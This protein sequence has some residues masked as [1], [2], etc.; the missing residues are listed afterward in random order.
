MLFQMDETEIDH[1]GNT[2]HGM[3]LQGIFIW[4]GL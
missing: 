4:E 1:D 3:S 2:T